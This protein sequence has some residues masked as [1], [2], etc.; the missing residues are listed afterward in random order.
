M[1]FTTVLPKPY[2]VSDRKQKGDINFMGTRE[3]EE[4]RRLLPHSAYF[5][6]L[7]FK[8]P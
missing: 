8:L 4:S 5:W 2:D 3:A 7:E 6:K 1:K